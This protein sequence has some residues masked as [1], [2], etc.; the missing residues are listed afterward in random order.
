[1]AEVLV[2]T[3]FLVRERKIYIYTHVQKEEVDSNMTA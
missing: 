3:I 1:M 2:P